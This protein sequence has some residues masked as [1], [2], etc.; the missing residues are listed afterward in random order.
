MDIAN[1]DIKMNFEGHWLSPFP[2]SLCGFETGNTAENQPRFPCLESWLNM[3]SG[4]GMSHIYIVNMDIKMNF[5][6]H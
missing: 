6:F 3:V 2:L 4:C 5:G 1:M